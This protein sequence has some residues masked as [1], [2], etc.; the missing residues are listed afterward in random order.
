MARQILAEERNAAA[1]I[2]SQWDAAAA[3]SL[4]SVGAR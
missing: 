1:T 4:E 2:A 3:A